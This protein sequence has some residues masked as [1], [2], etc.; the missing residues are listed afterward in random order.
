M[1]MMMR[2][3]WKALLGDSTGSLLK[4]EAAWPYSRREVAFDVKIV[5]TWLRQRLLCLHSGVI[6]VSG[7]FDVRPVVYTDINDPLHLTE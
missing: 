1:T 4:G 3:D 6:P 7:V 2:C 5:L